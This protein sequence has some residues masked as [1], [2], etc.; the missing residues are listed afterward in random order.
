[1]K[2]QRTITELDELIAR[3]TIIIKRLTYAAISCLIGVL[4]LGL[5]LLSLKH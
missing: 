3:D 5:F 2:P 1:M 4:S